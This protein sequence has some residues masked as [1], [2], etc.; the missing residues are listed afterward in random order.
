MIRTRSEQLLPAMIRDE[1]LDTSNYPK[2][3]PLYSTKFASQIGKF[4]DESAGVQ[5]FVDCIFL[6]PKLYSLKSDTTK[7]VIKAKGVNT[8]QA[9]ITHQHYVDIF[10]NGGAHHVKQRR[11]GSQ[12]HQLY[13]MATTKLALSCADDK[14]SWIAHNSS[15]A[16]GHH[17]LL[18]RGE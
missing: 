10:M 1:L 14:R 11:I 6:R 15:L 4:K 9:A 12:Q 2:D 13:T 8:R 7:H 17:R 16:Y 18:H 3:H 5:R